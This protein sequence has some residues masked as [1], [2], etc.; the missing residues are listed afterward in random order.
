MP[1][2]SSD[3]VKEISNHVDW[4]KTVIFTEDL[5]II[6]QS[7]NININDININHI[8]ELLEYFDGRDKSVSKGLYIFD[9]RFNIYRYHPPLVYGR[10]GSPTQSKGVCLAKGIRDGTTVYCLITYKLPVLSSLAVPQLI[11][12]FRHHIGELS[13]SELFPSNHNLETPK[14]PAY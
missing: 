9:V 11:K 2:S 13:E 7:S 4:D 10:T 1:S 6:A 14:D 8:K 3:L 5:D 12:F